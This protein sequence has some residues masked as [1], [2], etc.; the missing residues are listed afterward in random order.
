VPAR[1]RSHQ[2]TRLGDGGQ[3]GMMVTEGRMQESPQ[4]WSVRGD[5]Y[6]IK[7]PLLTACRFYFLASAAQSRVGVRFVAPGFGP[8]RSYSFRVRVIRLFP[9]PYSGVAVHTHTQN[10]LLLLCSRLPCLLCSSLRRVLRSPFR[11]YQKCSLLMRR[12]ARPR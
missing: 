6:I 5:K 9:Y 2:L 3:S 11:S 8:K 7:A 12:W 10:I 1:G 4:P